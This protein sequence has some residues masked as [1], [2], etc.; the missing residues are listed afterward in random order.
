MEEPDVRTDTF[1]TVK[2]KYQNRTTERIQKRSMWYGGT[3]IVIEYEKS[4]RDENEVVS[5]MEKIPDAMRAAQ[6]ITCGPELLAISGMALEFPGGGRLGGLRAWSCL[7]APRI[8]RRSAA[9]SS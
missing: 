8:P 7:V 1:E 2:N 6:E 3:G 9:P 5:A 4:N